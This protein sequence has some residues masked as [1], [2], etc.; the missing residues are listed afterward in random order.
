MTSNARFFVRKFIMMRVLQSLVLIAFLAVAAFAE[1]TGSLR[2]KIT[3]PR[4]LEGV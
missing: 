1:T 2:G 3:D 4:T